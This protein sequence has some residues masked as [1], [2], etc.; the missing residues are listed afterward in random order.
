MRFTYEYVKE[1]IEKYGDKLITDNYKNYRQRLEVICHKCH[2]Q[3]D[4]TFQV[5]LR[6]YWCTGKCKQDNIDNKVNR[7][8]YKF[9][10]LHDIQ[11]KVQARG[12]TLHS[13]HYINGH[14]KLDIQCGTC[15]KH[16][17]MKF[18]S[19]NAGKQGCPHCAIQRRT[20]TEAE[21]C[22]SVTERGDR[23]LSNYVNSRTRVALKC[24]KC[25]N[26]YNILGNQ[27][28]QGGGCQKCSLE[29]MKLTYYEVKKRV[30]YYGDT[31]LSKTYVNTSTPLN[32]SCGLCGK[33]YQ[34][35]LT[36]RYIPNCKHCNATECEKYIHY[37]LTKA[38][39]KYVTQKT[40]QD[41][42]SAKGYLFRYDFYLPDSNTIIEADGIQ[43]F[44]PQKKFGGKDWFCTIQQR[45]VMKTK[46]C[47][48]NGI[49][50]VRISCLEMKSH[51]HVKEF[52]DYALSTYNQKLVSTSNDEL[53]EY[54]LKNV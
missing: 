30:E 13:D 33:N 35:P 38:K 41:C 6:G 9:Y 42:R 29:G 44:K 47:I 15:E 11:S 12:D 28:R 39:L 14:Q 36:S 25:S 54:I 31:L 37:Y 24:G 21:F 22:K 43:H 45:D 49:K 50:L 4:Q 18:L 3:Y 34:K 32:I 26:E 46:Y 1:F 5:M 51:E 8:G 40:Y 7:K 20:L 23:M 27:Y 52:L 10:T 16:F 19:Y 2:I 17:S 48:E 53:Y